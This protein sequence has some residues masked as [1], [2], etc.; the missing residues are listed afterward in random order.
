[1]FSNFFIWCAGSDTNVLSKCEGSVRTKHVGLGTLVVIPAILGFVSMSYALTTIELVNANKYLP[2][3]G[4]AVWGMIIF[5]FDRY[6]VSTHRKKQGNISELTSITFYLRLVFAFVLGIVVSHPIVVL[7]FNGSITNRIEKDKVEAINREESSHNMALADYSQK[8]KELE[9]KK[10]CLQSA[11][12]AEET[13]LKKV[14]DCG[15]STSGHPN[16]NSNGSASQYPFTKEIQKRIELADEEIKAE[17]ERIALYMQTTLL[18]NKERSIKR[19]NDAPSDYLKREKTLEKL[20]KENSIVWLT[21]FFLMLAF[22]LVDILPLIFKTFSPF[23][24]YDKILVD[25]SDILKQLNIESRTKSLQDAYDDISSDYVAAF[26]KAWNIARISKK[27]Q[28]NKNILIGFC[29]GIVI[30]IGL[31]LYG[32]VKI[33]TNQ[34]FS[35]MTISS[36]VVSI[37][38]NFATDLIKKIS[39]SLSE[40]L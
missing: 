17:K 3:L 9:D 29:S 24:M 40:P 14:F 6:I 23:S 26:S 4:G 8:L 11:K 25:D 39:I 15:V 1:M 16:H 2:L 38:S 21:Q 28:F 10:S 20:V 30:T 33:S 35:L 13:G 32:D 18:P 5:A 27:Y 7:I 12:S 31:F 19:I 36:I 34:L 37:I 22:M